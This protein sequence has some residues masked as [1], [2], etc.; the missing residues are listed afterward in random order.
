MPITLAPG[1][2]LHC[3]PFAPVFE[4]NQGRG[5]L[6]GHCFLNATQ[7]SQQSSLLHENVANVSTIPVYFLCCEFFHC[8]CQSTRL[9][10]RIWNHLWKVQV[11]KPKALEFKRPWLSDISSWLTVK[12]NGAVIWVNSSEV[13]DS[14]IGVHDT[15]HWIHKEYVQSLLCKA[16]NLS[17]IWPCEPRARK[18]QVYH[19]AS[20]KTVLEN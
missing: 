17:Q 16:V 19:I 20:V 15:P 11:W 9:G 4:V 3:I 1:L 14:R 7:P 2:A 5:R 12:E 8:F 18:S 10:P 6:D 13:G